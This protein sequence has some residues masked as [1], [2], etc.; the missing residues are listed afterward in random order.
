MQ[1]EETARQVRDLVEKW[2][3]SEA[4]DHER[5]FQS[6]LT[7]YLDEQLNSGGMGI[8][9]NQGEYVV[10]TEHG[11]SKGDVVVNDH[12]GIELKRDFTNSQKKKLQGQIEDYRDEYDHVIACA[13][14]IED[15]D[16]WRRLKNKYEGDGFD[17]LEPQKAAVRFVHKP[18]AEFGTG[19][20]SAG[21]SGS[22]SLSSGVG[23][24][25]PA[26]AELD[27]AL[28]E[29]EDAP[30]EIQLFVLLVAL[31]VAGYIVLTIL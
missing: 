14:G 19:G 5:K 25:D 21:S 20:R 26:G 8:G 13:C 24:S 10:S 3:P 11:T 17:P 15:M 31:A 7:E 22:A 18:K 4:Y 9:M 23:S 28:E 1:R 29:L 6:E 12:V 2:T 16:G 27:N 30:I